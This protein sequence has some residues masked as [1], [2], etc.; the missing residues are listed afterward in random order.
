M[1]NKIL[2]YLEEECITVGGT[3]VGVPCKFPFVYDM[4]DNLPYVPASMIRWFSN[5]KIFNNCTDYRK[6]S[7]RS[8]CA[9]K[10]TADNRYIPGHWGE[11]PD[12]NVC[13]L[14][15]GRQHKF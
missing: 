8:W 12:S 3:Q 10:T 2:F 14:V 15:E 9:T 1:I 11:C 7:G 6:N 13:N 4:L 5:E